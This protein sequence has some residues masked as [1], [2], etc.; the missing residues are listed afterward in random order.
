MQPNDVHYI[1]PH[2]QQMCETVWA[3]MPKWQSY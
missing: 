2:L 1:T 3:T